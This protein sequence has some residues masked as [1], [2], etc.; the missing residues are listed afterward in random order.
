MSGAVFLDFRKAFDMVRHDILLKKLS[1]YYLSIASI[2]FTQSYLQGRLQCV[3]VNG[4]YSQET[5][6]K[7][8][9]PQGSMLGPLL[10]C[11]FINDVHMRLTRPSVQC[12]LFSA[13]VTLN[14]ANDNI[15][16]TRRDLQ[17]SLNDISVWCCRNLMA[18][19]PTKTK[20][21]LMATRHKH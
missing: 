12:D 1:S 4:T 9:V 8:G 15:G 11:I 5:S 3:I 17:Q 2:T 13:D 20:C 19:N 14:T 21:M 18:L 6:I 7:S 10:F 16:N